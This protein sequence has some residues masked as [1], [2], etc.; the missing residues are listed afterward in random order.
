[1]RSAAPAGGS[2]CQSAGDLAR[3]GAVFLAGGRAQGGAQLVSRD[4]IDQ[5]QDRQVAVPPTLVADWWGL[6]PYGSTWEGTSVLGHSG[7]NAGGSSFLRWV[8]ERDIAVVTVVNCPSLGYAFAKRAFEEL[9]HALAGIN[10][11]AAPQP[12]AG[13]AIDTTR[14]VG[15]Y[16]MVGLRYDVAAAGEGL[17]L[18]GPTFG[19]GPLL[20]LTPST[21]LPTDPA[22]D[23]NR[24]WALAFL[25][26]EDQPATHLLNGLLAMRRIATSRGSS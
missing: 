21:F 16:E 15:T 20:P 18:S 25:G 6:G 5:M 12:A 22:V 19:P 7:T 14:L 9:F 11:P 26:P 4:T 3:L 17:T 24:G 13:V 2:L 23:G 10:V 1:M 8:P